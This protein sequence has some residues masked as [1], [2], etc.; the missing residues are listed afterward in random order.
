MSSNQSNN[1]YQYEPRAVPLQRQGAAVEFDAS[2]LAK[3]QEEWKKT[4]MSTTT[5]TPINR[6]NTTY[7]MP[8][9]SRGGRRLKSKRMRVK[10]SRRRTRG[11]GR[12]GSRRRH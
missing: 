6:T 10:S 7:G 1:T 3:M 2:D 4:P 8:S 11:R 12:R 9:S 5:T